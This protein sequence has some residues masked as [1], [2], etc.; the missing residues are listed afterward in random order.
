MVFHV[1]EQM[2][3]VRV[4]SRFG[5]LISIL[6]DPSFWHMT[7]S[8]K[9]GMTRYFASLFLLSTGLRLDD[10]FPMV[11]LRSQRSMH[12]RESQ[13]IRTMTRVSEAISDRVVL[14]FGNLD[15]AN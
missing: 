2:L 4:A 10:F 5:L 13:R 9:S 1:T 15:Q 7:Q 14:L 12:K 3:H 11:C 8:K 6:I